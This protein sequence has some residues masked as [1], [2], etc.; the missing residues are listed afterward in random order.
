MFRGKQTR[1]LLLND[2]ERLERTLFRLEQGRS[3]S[4]I[5]C[6]ANANIFIYVII[7]CAIMMFIL[8][9]S[10][11]D[12]WYHLSF[13]VL[14][15]HIFVYPFYFSFLITLCNSRLWTPAKLWIDL[16]VT[17]GAWAPNITFKNLS[18]I[19]SRGMCWCSVP[20]CCGAHRF[21]SVDN[22]NIVY[23]TMQSS[24]DR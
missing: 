7:S 17:R 5:L 22:V 9:Y 14:L 13:L 15:M 3:S 4:H 19:Y 2:M 1:V 16:R 10:F 12:L 20:V 24:D 21:Y 6:I 8:F 11:I 18:A 23:Y